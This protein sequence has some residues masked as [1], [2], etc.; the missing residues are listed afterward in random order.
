[1]VIYRGHKVP[2]LLQQCDQVML[3][4]H[5]LPIKVKKTCLVVVEASFSNGVKPQCVGKEK[6]MTKSVEPCDFPKVPFMAE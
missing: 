5:I 2:Q 3:A 6:Q 1:M 4:T